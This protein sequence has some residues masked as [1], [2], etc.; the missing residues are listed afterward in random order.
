MMRCVCGGGGGGDGGCVLKSE[1]FLH[2][3]EHVC[4][5]NCGEGKEWFTSI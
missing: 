1:T 4:V 3:K 2:D 5:K